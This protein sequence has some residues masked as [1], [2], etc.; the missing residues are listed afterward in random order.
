[1][2]WH[3]EVI[4]VTDLSQ[5]HVETATLTAIE[6]TVG[7]GEGIVLD[8]IFLLQFFSIPA[9]WGWGRLSTCPLQFPL[10]LY[11]SKADL[12]D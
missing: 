4:K 7:E 10:A 6:S 3:R 2:D 8:C 12:G 5:F 9:T 1:M 11:Y